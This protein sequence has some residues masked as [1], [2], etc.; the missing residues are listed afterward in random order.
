MRIQI[1]DTTKINAIKNSEAGLVT[2]KT[3]R[4]G[5]TDQLVFEDLFGENTSFIGSIRKCYDTTESENEYDFSVDKIIRGKIQSLHVLNEEN[6]ADLRYLK[7][8][9]E[10]DF[11]FKENEYTLAIR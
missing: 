2:G 3:C 8:A 1:N 6:P 4:F 11:E 5:I 9:L 10:H 7:L